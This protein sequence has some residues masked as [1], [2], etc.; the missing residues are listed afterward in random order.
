MSLRTGYPLIRSALAG[1]GC[2]LGEQVGLGVVVAVK[3]VVKRVSDALH[4]G[5]V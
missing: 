1:R 3:V 5:K 2:A 4:V